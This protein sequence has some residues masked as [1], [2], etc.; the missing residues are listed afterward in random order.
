MSVLELNTHA[1]GG[2][3]DIPST[4]FLYNVGVSLI[5]QVINSIF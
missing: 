5:P 4:G 2:S 1:T 3:E